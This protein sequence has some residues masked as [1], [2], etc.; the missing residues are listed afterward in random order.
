MMICDVLL[1]LAKA[2]R[3]ML[4]C[5]LQLSNSGTSAHMSAG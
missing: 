2:V 4:S 3:S 5:R 1:H